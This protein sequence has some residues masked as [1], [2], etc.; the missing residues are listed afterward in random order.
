ML[1]NISDQALLHNVNHL[2]SVFM[3]FISIK[4][5][6]S[7]ALLLVVSVIVSNVVYF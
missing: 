4:R 2:E 3:Q 7:L 5:L 1:Y 6:E